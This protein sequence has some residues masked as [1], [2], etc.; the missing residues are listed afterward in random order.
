MEQKSSGI[1]PD[2]RLIFAPVADLGSFSRAAEGPGWPRSGTTSPQVILSPP[3]CGVLG[4][5]RGRVRGCRRHR[6]AHQIRCAGS[7]RASV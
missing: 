6:R 2:D 5:C 4:T 1:D 3:E 7:R